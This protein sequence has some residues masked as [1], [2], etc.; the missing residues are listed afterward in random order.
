MP[1]KALL[2]KPASSRVSYAPEKYAGIYIVTST[3]GMATDWEMVRAEA[4]NTGGEFADRTRVLDLSTG[5]N[6]QIER[7]VGQL[8]SD[9]NAVVSRVVEVGATT[10]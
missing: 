9:E 6:L 8:G 4:F 5:K 10:T 2:E 1:A 3:G 7:L